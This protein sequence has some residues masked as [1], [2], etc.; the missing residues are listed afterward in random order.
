MDN[1]L[2]LQDDFTVFR[3]SVVFFIHIFAMRNS[4]KFL[5]FFLIEKFYQIIEYVPSVKIYLFDFYEFL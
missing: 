5:P 2:D 1:S 4:N 3:K